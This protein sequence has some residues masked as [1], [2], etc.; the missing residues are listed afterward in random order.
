MVYLTLWLTLWNTH[1]H[2]KIP[3]VYKEDKE[4]REKK[5]KRGWGGA[6]RGEESCGEEWREAARPPAVP[7]R[8]RSVPLTRSGQNALQRGHR[9]LPASAH[10][11]AARGELWSRPRQPLA[12][13]PP[14]PGA[15]QL[16][17]EKA[18][19]AAAP[20]PKHAEEP[21]PPRCQQQLCWFKTSPRKRRKPKTTQET[22][23]G[24]DRAGSPESGL[25]L[26]TSQ[27]GRAGPEPPAALAPPREV[28]APSPG[29]PRG[30]A[31]RGQDRARTSPHRAS[32]PGRAAALSPEGLEAFGFLKDV[33]SSSP[34]GPRSAVGSAQGGEARRRAAPLNSECPRPCGRGGGSR[35]PPG[36]P[37]AGCHGPAP[38]PVQPVPQRS[39]PGRG[40]AWAAAS[41]QLGEGARPGP[42]QPLIAHGKPTGPQPPPG[43][44]AAPR[45]RAAPQEGHG[46]SR[47][48]LV[49]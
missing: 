2:K 24:S 20:N 8:P 1:T 3:N 25:L 43:H 44:G 37:P 11:P 7:A 12:A 47:A 28:P 26:C 19:G 17:R 49:R 33:S 16:Y 6:R 41:S 14:R 5:K 40:K 27:A 32:G 42:G 4:R 35:E 39:W 23:G 48:V 18:E 45:P 10:G 22:K 46:G 15:Q 31:G 13:L 38:L 21:G 29:V 36:S 9:G 30:S 34:A